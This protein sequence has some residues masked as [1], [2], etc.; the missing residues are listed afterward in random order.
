M[1]VTRAYYLG[2]CKPAA[3]FGAF[4]TAGERVGVDC[5]KDWV[6]TAVESAVGGVEGVEEVVEGAAFDEVANWGWVSHCFS[7]K[8]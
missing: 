5:V 8:L 7:N 3:V 2:G 4:E 6:I 1:A